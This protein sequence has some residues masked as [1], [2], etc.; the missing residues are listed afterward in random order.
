MSTEPRIIACTCGT[1]YQRTEQTLPIKDIGVF[2]C[3]DC[4]AR[5]DMWSGRV[6]PE[7]KRIAASKATRRSA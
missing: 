1:S 6:V 4:G 3:E 5:L 2:E 7:F